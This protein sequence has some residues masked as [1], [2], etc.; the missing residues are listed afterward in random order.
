MP[1]ECCNSPTYRLPSC[2]FPRGPRHDRNHPPPCGIR[3]RNRLRGARSGGCRAHPD[4]APG[5]GRHLHSRAQRRGTERFDGGGAAPP[6]T[7]LRQRKRHRRRRRV[8]AACRGAVQRQPR[9]LAR[10]RRH[11]RERLDS[12]ER[13][14]RPGRAGCRGD[15]RSER[16]HR[17]RR[18]R[19]RVRGADSPEPRSRSVRPL[20]AGIP[21]HADLRSIWCGVGGG[22][23]PRA[24][25][26]ADGGRVRTVR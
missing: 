5:P 17:R 4:A 2:D 12:S 7:R 15:G 11:P 20:P 19:R 22:S 1:S 8:L 26:I 24:G 9:P 16:P 21:S 6:R 25:R 18:G 10:L 14:D 23:G 3:G 13:A